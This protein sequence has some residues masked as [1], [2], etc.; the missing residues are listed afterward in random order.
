[1]ETNR[2]PTQRQIE[3]FDAFARLGDQRLA[4]RA[5]GLSVSRLKRNVLEHN[6]RL[7][8][9]SSIQAAYLRWAPKA[10]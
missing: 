3:C 10:G 2:P 5:L 6:R 1:M 4:A 8:A 7:G 9:N